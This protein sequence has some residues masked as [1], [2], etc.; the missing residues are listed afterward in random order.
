MELDDVADKLKAAG[1]D[2]GPKNSRAG[3][4][5]TGFA[6]IATVFGVV[7]VATDELANVWRNEACLS[8]FGIGAVFFAVALG[9]LAG[10]V[11]QP[12]KKPERFCLILGNILLGAGLI[13]L[14]FAGLSLASDRP[15]PGI[16]AKPTEKDGT[17]ALAVT[18][19]DSKLH[20]D[21][22]LG[23]AVEPLYEIEEEK[24]NRTVVH[25]RVGRPFYA[26]SLPPDS[27]GNVDHDVVVEIPAG[28]FQDVG[29]RA[30]DQSRPDCYEEPDPPGCLLVR[31]PQRSEEPQFSFKWRKPYRPNATLRVRV[32]ALDI[33]GNALRFRALQTKPHSKILAQATLPP[34]PHGD[35][36]HTFALPVAGSRVVCVAASTAE[37]KLSCPPADG[38][39]PSWVRL[40][41]PRRR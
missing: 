10:W 8:Y 39:S 23:V 6:L 5:L 31:I 4:L 30:S 38:Q 11:L 17:T 35:V 12:G 9:A 36:D 33:P 14:A 7:G 13:L 22:N 26:A 27:D 40:R 20:A 24:P 29:V 21:Q 16:T 1:P 25:Y 34:N 2:V 18:V 41:V 3:Y 15:D 37:G 28:N 19:K 32:R